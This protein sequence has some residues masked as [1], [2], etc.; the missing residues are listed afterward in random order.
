MPSAIPGANR[1]RQLPPAWATIRPTFSRR[2]RDWP[3]AVTDGDGLQPVRLRV[4]LAYGV[5]TVL[6]SCVLLSAL[7]P[8]PM[9]ESAQAINRIV[10]GSLLLILAIA[11]LCGLCRRWAVRRGCTLTGMW[12]MLSPV[13]LPG[14]FSLAVASAGLAT[15]V[16]AGLASDA[17]E[18]G[19]WR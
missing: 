2:I 1:L 8:R 10:C 18:L 15:F 16:A 12:L 13:L 19:R 3:D 11:S 6:A 5:V 7:T 9:L 4:R 17:V 14:P